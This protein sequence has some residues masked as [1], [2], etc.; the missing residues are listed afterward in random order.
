[1][2]KLQKERNKLFLLTQFQKKN[3]HPLVNEGNLL[4]NCQSMYPDAVKSFDQDMGDLAA[5]PQS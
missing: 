2:E 1:M 3:C 5:D 4:K